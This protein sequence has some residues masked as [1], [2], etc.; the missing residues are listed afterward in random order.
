MDEAAFL[1]ALPSLA[2]QAMLVFARM[3][4]SVMLLPAL[5]ESDLPAPYRLGMGL[6]FV[7][8]LLPVLEPSLPPA[9]DAVADVLRLVLIE[10]GIGIWIGSLARL[11]MLGLSVAAQFM[12][13][14]IGLTSAMV[15]DP[16]VG[17]GGTALSRLVGL[18]AL[19]MVMA[20]GLHHLPIAAMAESYAVLPP[21]IGFPAAEATETIVAMGAESLD[22]ALRLSAPF[23]LG[24][25]VANV[26]LG[27]LSRVAPQI[28]IY[29]V[30]VPGQVLAGLVLL[31][32]IIPSLLNIAMPALQAAFTALPGAR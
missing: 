15:Q 12:A 14:A 23:M 18:A 24:A 2:F 1:A 11:A 5:G 29:F 10:I 25:V 27:L 31:G 17:Q 20:M 7:P 3:G 30:A 32:L 26:A 13:A 28:Q 4:A 21:G 8:V 9:P 22:L 6:A 16:T 19:V